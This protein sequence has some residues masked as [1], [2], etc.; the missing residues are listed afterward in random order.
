MANHYME[1]RRKINHSFHQISNVSQNHRI[2]FRTDSDPAEGNSEQLLRLLDV[3]LCVDRQIFKLADLGDGGLPAWHRDV[4]HLDTLVLIYVGGVVV[5][6]DSILDVVDTNLDLVKV[7]KNINLG[8]SQGGVSIDLTGEPQQGYVQPSTSSW[9]SCRHS[10]LSSNS[11]Q[12]CSN[13]ITATLEI[14]FYNQQ[15]QILR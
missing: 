1:I 3:V 12:C 10:E 15:S 9:S 8:Q 4:L 6:H 2:S 11:L 5:H 14:D 13:I 7:I